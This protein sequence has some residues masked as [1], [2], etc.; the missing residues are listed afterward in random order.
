MSTDY[1][2]ANLHKDSFFRALA[3]AGS[4]LSPSIYLQNLFTGKISLTRSIND[5][6]PDHHV[7]LFN[8][9]KS[10]LHIVL[11]AISS[12]TGKNTVA[13]S[14]YTCPDVATAA[15]DADC[16]IRLFDIQK[17]NLQPEPASV[18]NTIRNEDT[19]AI[20]LSNLYGYPDIL[21]IDRPKGLYVIHDACQSF[22]NFCGSGNISISN[23]E[24][25]IC[26]F[27]RGKAFSAAGGGMLLIPKNDI[28][29]KKLYFSNIHKAVEAAYRS[30]PFES[31]KD[32]FSYIIKLFVQSIFE[33]P[34]LFWIF[35]HL[36]GTGIGTTKVKMNSPCLRANK[37]TITGI[38][39]SLQHIENRLGE[40]RTSISLYRK[41]NLHPTLESVL[42]VRVPV[43]LSHQKRTEL[44]DS[45]SCIIKYGIRF[46]YPD[47]I[48][49][50]P[51]IKPFIVSSGS[52]SNYRGAYD[53]SRSIVTLPLHKYVTQE[54]V[55]RISKLIAE[56]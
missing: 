28:E 38:F 6:F 48:C 21:S 51:Q 23:E 55:L 4:T 45:T 17:E 31:G 2:T 36:P 37:A 27:G 54:D 52:D 35:C 5:F 8:N 39:S 34:C 11:S 12:L 15:I 3:P 26:S 10:A 33:R 47:L 46:S 50:Y 49:N 13:M 1:R 25:T 14:A 32:A 20:I 16:H 22:L 24:I 53:V 30:L 19:G 41:M 40:I 43:L 44:A 56:E 29:S 7:Y 42:P 9:A 18:L